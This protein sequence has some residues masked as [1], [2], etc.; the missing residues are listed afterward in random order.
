MQG[1][2]AVVGALGSGELGPVTARV[3]ALALACLAAQN[4]LAGLG[5]ISQPQ[6]LP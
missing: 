2:S 5:R 1:R 6:P 3:T 4:G